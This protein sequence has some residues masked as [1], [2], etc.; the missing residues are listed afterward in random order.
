MFDPREGS[1]HRVFVL[2]SAPSRRAAVGSLVEQAGHA[3][4]FFASVL[5][6]LSSEQPAEAVLIDGSDANCPVHT[7]RAMRHLAGFSPTALV[8]VEVPPGKVSS[9]LQAGADDALAVGADPEELGVRLV[10][11]LEAR[12][13]NDRVRLS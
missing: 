5:D 9:M 4:V 6:V 12:R 11:A 7:A 10:H 1:T 13:N 2:S 8:G 3:P